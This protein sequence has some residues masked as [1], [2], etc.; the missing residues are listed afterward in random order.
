MV[1]LYERLT[2]QIEQEV[3]GNYVDESIL[4]LF[5]PKDLED[6]SI[7]E[8]VHKQ[9]KDIPEASLTAAGF[10]PSEA[11]LFAGEFS[12]KV[13]TSSEEMHLNEKD[14]AFA[15]KHGI[16][17]M[18]IAELGKK[19]AKG[20]SRFFMVGQNGAGVAVEG[21]TN[22]ITHAGAGTLTSPSIITTA[23][24]GAWATW[25]NQNTDVTLLISQLE[26]NN[27]NLATTVVFYPKAASKAMRR[28]GA[29]ALEHSALEHF[30]S[31]GIQ[32][33]AVPNIYLY[34]AAGATPAIAAFDLYAI[35][36][37]KIKIGYTRKQVTKVIGAHDEQR[38]TIVQSE[39]WFVPY[40]IPQPF[41]DGSVKKGVSRI[42][43]INGT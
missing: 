10:N 18:G 7:S 26:E 37:S 2:S 13:F 5:T 8:W 1:T 41:S 42:T 16:A 17:D 12:H 30:A 31:M 20:A 22:Y 40:M 6:I 9:F 39:V 21:N 36:M 27:Y 14:W 3:N 23:T 43:A 19:V 28:H 4:E 38:D 35:D 32:C 25:A 29:N 33:V 11:T 15:M 24:A 34:T